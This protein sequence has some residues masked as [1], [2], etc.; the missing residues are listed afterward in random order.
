M[1]GIRGG[2]NRNQQ[3][4]E[5]F[6]KDSRSIQFHHFRAVGITRSKEFPLGSPTLFSREA[7]TLSF[8]RFPCSFTESISRILQNGI[9][10]QSVFFPDF[11]QGPQNISEP[12]RLSR[13]DSLDFQT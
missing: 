12:S 3:I 5:P 4:R 2:F 6:A 1:R 10:L 9:P 11:D 7:G 13:P 8:G